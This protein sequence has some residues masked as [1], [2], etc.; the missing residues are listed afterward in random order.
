ME[1]RTLERELY[2]AATAADLLHV[3][4][5]TLIWWLDGAKRGDKTYPPV[6]RETA[7]GSRNVTWAEFIEAGL[8]KQYR[9]EHQ[10]KLDELRRFIAVIRDRFGV[11]YPLAEKRPFVGEGRRLLLELQREFEVPGELWLVAPTTDEVVLTEPGASFIHRV[12][13]DENLAV[14]WRPH[15]DP[16]SPVR[17]SPDYRFGRPSIG[18]IS[19]NAIAEHVEGGEGEE[20]VADQFGLSVDDVQWALA[21]E[22]SRRSERAA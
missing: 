2:T 3:P 17:C 21:Y 15:D 20:D 5:E 11:P 4:T 22:L 12:E 6:I 1:V 9:R 10:V 8:L 19:T 13:W 16:A 18:G 7:T 14:A